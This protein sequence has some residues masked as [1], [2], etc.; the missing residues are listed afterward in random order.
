[1]KKQSN[2]KKQ[3]K[4]SWRIPFKNKTQ[5]RIIKPGKKYTNLKKNNTNIKNKIKIKYERM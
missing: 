3:Y 4:T 5:N 1:M 2:T